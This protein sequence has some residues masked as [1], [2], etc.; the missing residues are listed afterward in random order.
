MYIRL[1]LIAMFFFFSFFTKAQNITISGK[2]QDDETKKAVQGATIVLK[3]AKDTN[4]VQTTFSDS[5]GRFRF[6]DLSR[7]SF[8][9]SFSS[10]GYLNLSRRIQIDNMDSTIKD[11][12]IILF[13]KS[14]KELAGVTVVGRTPPAQ[15]KGDT[16]QFNASEFKVN[17]DA[18]ARDN[19]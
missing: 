11:L 6:T 12:G 3:S 19:C 5:A 4:F 14:A 18:S 2:L 16:L 17:P 9:I 7:D 15:Q 1:A 13:S 8:L 10:V